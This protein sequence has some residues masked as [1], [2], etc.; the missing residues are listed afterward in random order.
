[1]TITREFINRYLINGLRQNGASESQA[2]AIAGRNLNAAVAFL[3]PRFSL[4]NI[5]NMD[6]FGIETAKWIKAVNPT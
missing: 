2:K 5:Q 1:M 4:Q 6:Q 3:T